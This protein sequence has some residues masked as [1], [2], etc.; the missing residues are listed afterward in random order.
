MKKF[1]TLC[2]EIIMVF[3]ILCSGMVSAHAGEQWTSR[4][5][6]KE[7]LF[8]VNGIKSDDVVEDYE[9]SPDSC[10][11]RYWGG[12]TVTG[13][14][15]PTLTEGVDYEILNKGED[16]I[17]FK[18]L[19]G[20]SCVPYI[21]VLVDFEH[22][23]I[24][25]DVQEISLYINGARSFG[26]VHSEYTPDDPDGHR[27]TYTGDGTVT[28]WEFPNLTEGKN[29]E[30]IEQKE[31]YIDI[32]LINGQDEIPDINVLVA[33]S[34]A[35][36]NEGQAI[37]KGENSINAGSENGQ[38]KNNDVNAVAGNIVNDTDS[39][40]LIYVVAGVCVVAAVLIIIVVVKKNKKN[41]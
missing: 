4:T 35:K 33:F 41:A 19:N 26:D 22:W 38:D 24:R 25:S 18:I 15:F 36:E 39:M 28:G 34:N 14:E 9:I 27:F 23:P 21:N 10:H 1:L 5:D 8:Y 29:Y 7:P 13:W 30:I 11:Y 17:E 40:A 16:D 6:F 31:N 12:G 3:V 20:Q 37:D 2:T 32:K